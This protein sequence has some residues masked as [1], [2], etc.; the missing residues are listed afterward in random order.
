MPT[1]ATKIAADAGYTDDD[2]TNC[3]VAK[4][5]AGEDDRIRYYHYI[6]CR[7]WRRH[8]IFH[9]CNKR[10]YIKWIFYYRYK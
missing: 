10:W 1:A 4:N 6:T 7:I 3:V 8:Y 2:I 9:G 5:D